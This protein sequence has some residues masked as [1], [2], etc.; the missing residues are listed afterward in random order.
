MKS[1]K[2]GNQLRNSY[3]GNYSKSILFLVSSQMCKAEY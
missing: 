1:P 3:L 2:A